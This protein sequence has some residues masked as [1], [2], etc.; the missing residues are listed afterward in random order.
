[1]AKPKNALRRLV[2]HRR[3]LAMEALLLVNAAV[4]YAENEFLATNLQN[5]LKVLVVMALVLGFFGAL[6]V[7]IEAA[8]K[9][10]LAKTHDMIQK[11]PFPT[12]ILLVHSCIWLGLFALYVWL[13]G[14]WPLW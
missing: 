6:L 7:V 1:M 11:M 10:G 8:S 12:P 4:T 9:A 2:S 3:L 13:Y 5:W 14:Y